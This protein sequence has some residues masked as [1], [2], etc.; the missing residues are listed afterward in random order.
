MIMPADG[1]AVYIDFSNFSE[2]ENTFNITVQYQ[3][4][5][6]TACLSFGY[7]L[8]DEI[9]QDNEITKSQNDRINN[10]YVAVSVWISVGTFFNVA[11]GDERQLQAPHTEYMAKMMSSNFMARGIFSSF[12][13]KVVKACVKS[14]ATVGIA[15]I[16]ITAMVAAPIIPVV[17]VSVALHSIVYGIMFAAMET[18]AELIAISDKL[19]ALREAGALNVYITAFFE[20]CDNDLQS[21]LKLDFGGGIDENGYIK[22]HTGIEFPNKSLSY[23]DYPKFTVQ[24]R[25]PS[26]SKV[27]APPSPRW[28]HEQ[29]L[30]NLFEGTANPVLTNDTYSFVLKRKYDAE[31][32]RGLL[33]LVINFTFDVIINDNPDGV[34]FYNPYGWSYPPDS[35]IPNITPDSGHKLHKNMLYLWFVNPDD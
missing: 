28:D 27:L 3:G 30:Y 16:A 12:I 11:S 5:S 35:G 20:N 2:S 8:V 15:V 32:D 14:F 17:V 19:D 9:K 29:T 21:L 10:L 26:I 22:N 4:E 7:N 6:E 31:N 23:T 25:F 34:F 24:M 33:I 1:N 18:A 13:K